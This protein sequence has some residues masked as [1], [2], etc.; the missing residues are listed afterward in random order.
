MNQKTLSILP[1][2]FSDIEPIMIQESM[3]SP[4]TYSIS[5]NS[6]EKTILDIDISQLDND[7]IDVHLFPTYIKISGI[8]Q[9]S[10]M[11]DQTKSYKL[12]RLISEH[13]PLTDSISHNDLSVKKTDTQLIITIKHN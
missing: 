8:F 7:T 4:L 1:L 6:P 11:D 9:L 5:K 2:Q 3:V 13:I 12:S 10:L